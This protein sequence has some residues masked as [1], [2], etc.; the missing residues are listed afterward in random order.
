MKYK[1]PHFCRICRT[2]LFELRQHKSMKLKEMPECRTCRTTF[3][4]RVRVFINV[5]FIIEIIFFLRA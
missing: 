3:R 4:A 2:W 1:T 5:C